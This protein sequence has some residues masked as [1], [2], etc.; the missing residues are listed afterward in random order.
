MRYVMQ[1]PWDVLLKLARHHSTENVLS[2]MFDAALK[3]CKCIWNSFK[4]NDFSLYTRWCDQEHSDGQNKSFLRIPSSSDHSRMGSHSGVA[5]S[6]IVLFPNGEYYSQWHNG[7]V[8][9]VLPVCLLHFLWL[10][11]NNKCYNWGLGTFYVIIGKVE[12]LS[13]A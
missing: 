5:H 2:F 1:I 12:A 9:F 8:V 7:Y 13:K 10:S 3:Y 6:S 11:K 4:K